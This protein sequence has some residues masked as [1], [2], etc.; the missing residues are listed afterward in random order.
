[1]VHQGKPPSPRAKTGGTRHSYNGQY[2]GFPSPE[3]G[4]DPRMPL[5]CGVNATLGPWPAERND[6]G[7]RLRVCDR[8]PSSAA[9]T[10]PVAQ[11]IEPR[12]PKPRAAGPTPARGTR[13]AQGDAKRTTIRLHPRRSGMRAT[14]DRNAAVAQQAERPPRKRQVAGSYPACGSNNKTKEPTWRTRSNE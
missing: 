14:T 9:R 4:F 2:T 5:A 8:R 10:A 6:G 7:P 12:F 1:M 13:T 11:R 3:H